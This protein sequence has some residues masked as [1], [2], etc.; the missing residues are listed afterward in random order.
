MDEHLKKVTEKADSAL[1]FVDIR[2]PRR[3]LYI[4]EEELHEGD[5]VIIDRKKSTIELVYR[6]EEY[7]GVFVGDPKTLPLHSGRVGVGIK[8]P[9]IS[10][11]EPEDVD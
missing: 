1:E 3:V 2:G 8:E 11:E 10:D 4:I 6:K 7:D 9:G 5:A